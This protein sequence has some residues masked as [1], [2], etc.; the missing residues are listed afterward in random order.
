MSAFSGSIRDLSWL[1]VSPA[2]EKTLSLGV[3][4]ACT[5]RYDWARSDRKG[6][7]SLLFHH[8]SAGSSEVIRGSMSLYISSSLAVCSWVDKVLWIRFLKKRFVI[9][10]FVYKCDTKKQITGHFSYF[11]F[12]AQIKNRKWNKGGTTDFDFDIEFVR[13]AWTGSYLRVCVCVALW[14]LPQFCKELKE[15]WKN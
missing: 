15:A 11:W 5:Q 14:S 3:E 13:F 6:Y 10:L 12:N 4:E 2:V 1:I 8:Q 7:V 9:S